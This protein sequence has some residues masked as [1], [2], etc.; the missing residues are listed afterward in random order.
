[1]EKYK[2]TICGYV[3]DPEQGDPVGGVEPNTP[4]EEVHDQWLCP[5]CGAGKNEFELA[6]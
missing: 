2:C 3:Y 4:F 6:G 1:M 5:I